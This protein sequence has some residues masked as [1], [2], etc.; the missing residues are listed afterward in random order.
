MSVAAIIPAAGSG[1]R[2]QS[3]TPKPFLML[4][5]RPILAHTLQAMEDCPE[6]DS[7]V[8]VIGADY[9]E[10]CRREV[11]R[12]YNFKKV[13]QV[14][15]GGRERQ[16]SVYHGLKALPPGTEFVVVHDGAR[17]L[18]AP[19][20]IAQSVQEA[21]QWKAV[22]VGLPLKDTIKEVSEDKFILNTLKRQRLWA[23]QT[24]QTFSY[25][26]FKSALEDARKSNFMG[27]DEAS[28]VERLGHPVKMIPGTGFNL[29][30]TV[31]EDMA[32]AEA[33]L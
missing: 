16:D 20:L 22:I 30:I 4:G 11:V 26:L 24:P 1:V 5:G 18:I 32:L 13:A 14:V 8:V 33:L 29:K 12:K 31:P 9:V 23:A 6:V 25:E 7:V 2:M 28:L 3:D 10:R 15:T 21:R 27:T 17:P 19:S